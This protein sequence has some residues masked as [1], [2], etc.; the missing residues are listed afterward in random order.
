MLS[1]I[2]LLSGD[3]CHECAEIRGQHEMGLRFVN[4]LQVRPHLVQGGTALCIH[5]LCIR[6]IARNEDLGICVVELPIACALRIVVG[7]RT[8]NLAQYIILNI[9]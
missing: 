5:L 4:G 8:S 6:D 2:A 1:D 9:E 7:V 3:H